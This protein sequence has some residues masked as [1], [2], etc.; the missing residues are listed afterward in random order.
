MSKPA[1][2]DAVGDAAAGLRWVWRARWRRW[3]ILAMA[4]V[5]GLTVLAVAPLR[6]IDPPITPLMLTRLATGEADGLSAQTIGLED[7]AQVL[8]RSVLASEDMRFC[9]HR[10]VDWG[11]AR[12]AFAEYQAGQGLRGASTITMQTARSVFL[13]PSRTALRKV[14][15]LWLTPFIEFFWPK[16]RILEVYLNVAEWGSGVFGIEAAAQRA[17]GRSAAALSR[18]QAALLVS[19]LPNPIARNAAAPSQ[20]HRA[21]ARRLERRVGSADWSTLARCVES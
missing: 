5:M 12:A 13:P 11:Q 1:P 16:R 8:Q 17:F 7:S 15:E 3:P 9:A 18:G 20:A 4:A 21:I 2:R 14:A 19:A 10:G 6:W